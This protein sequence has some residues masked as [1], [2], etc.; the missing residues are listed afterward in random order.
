MVSASCLLARR[1]EDGALEPPS[2]T[3]DAKA[4]CVERFKCGRKN[5][6]FGSN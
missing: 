6:R 5:V 1:I 3:I 4:R 2:A